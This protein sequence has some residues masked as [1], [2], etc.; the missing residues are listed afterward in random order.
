MELIYLWVE[1]YNN[2]RMKG[3][4][5]SST[6]E[7]EFNDIKNVLTK[8]REKNTEKNFFGQN[9]SITTIVG[10]NGSGKSSLL[11]CINEILKTEKKIYED[12]LG[13]NMHNFNFAIFFNIGKTIHYVKNLKGE[14]ET[15]FEDDEYDLVEY[16][17]YMV[18]RQKNKIPFDLIDVAKKIVYDYGNKNSE[19]KLSSFMYLPNK[20]LIKSKKLDQLFD[21]EISSRRYERNGKYEPDHSFLERKANKF[22]SEMEYFVKEKDEFNKFKM[23]SGSEGISKKDF[24]KYFNHSSENNNYKLIKDLSITE[25]KIYFENCSNFFDFDFKD[26]NNKTFLDLSHG[27]KTLFGNLINIYYY[28]HISKS[29]NICFLFDEPDVFLHPNWQKKYINEILTLVQKIKISAH[30]LI[31]T[32]SPFLLSDLT[33]DNVIFLKKYTENDSDVHE[34]T[35]KVGNCN[36]LIDNININLFGA[37]IHTLLSHSFFMKDGLMGEFAKNK[38]NDILDFY[39]KTEELE[40]KLNNKEYTKERFKI[41]V[42]KL[43]VEYEKEKEGLIKKNYF[44]YIVSIIGDDYLRQVILNHLDEINRVIY[45]DDYLDMQI[46]VV[47]ENLNKLRDIKNARS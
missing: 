43:K 40:K 27:E 44:K 21:D 15:S 37:N 6:S 16:Y 31:T 34:G 11:E 1:E 20:I 3:F 47:E 45:Q 17:S 14:Y 13:I 18:D 2:I 7:Y 35:Q 38:I 23:I 22:N 42:N 5:F 4:N 19:F 36:N 32:H 30:F 33:K 9:I 25:R 28:C 39:K 10:E 8:K 29:K 41:S 24:K 12:D 26:E 46:R